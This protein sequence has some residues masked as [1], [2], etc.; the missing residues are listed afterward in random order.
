MMFLTIE[1]TSA[2]KQAWAS[3]AARGTAGTA[4]RQCWGPEGRASGIAPGAGHTWQ[5]LSNKQHNTDQVPLHRGGGV[6]GQIL[7]SPAAPSSLLTTSAASEPRCRA[8]ALAM[9]PA[10][11]C[12]AAERQDGFDLVLLDPC[13]WKGGDRAAPRVL[14]SFL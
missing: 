11:P 1:A 6:P 8:R 12:G 5:L 4:F 3:V 10:Q 14:L 13:R 9:E 2:N 7:L